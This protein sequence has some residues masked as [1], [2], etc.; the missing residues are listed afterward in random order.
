MAG[1]FCGHSNP[2]VNLRGYRQINN[3]LKSLGDEFIDAIY[4]GDLV[5]AVVTADAFAS[6][7]QIS[8]IVMP[9]LHEIYNFGDWEGLGWQEVESRDADYAH[10]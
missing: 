9:S 2:P 1:R 3:L 5:R 10:R 8:P 7:S 6:V 4:T